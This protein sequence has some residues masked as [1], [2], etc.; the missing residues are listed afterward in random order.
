MTALEHIPEKQVHTARR[1][2]KRDLC[3]ENSHIKMS[4]HKRGWWLK[5]GAK[6]GFS[7]I[8]TK[9]NHQLETSSE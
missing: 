4:D 5:E 9:E 3:L 6:H 7:G 8:Q 1:P 2:H